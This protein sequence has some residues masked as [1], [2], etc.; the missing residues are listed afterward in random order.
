MPLIQESAGGMPIGSYEVTYYKC[1]RT[2]PLKPSAGYDRDVS[3]AYVRR[4]A[5]KLRPFEALHAVCRSQP[6]GMWAYGCADAAAA[7]AADER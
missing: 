2:G 1:T 3:E 7:G 6:G 4:M 5:A